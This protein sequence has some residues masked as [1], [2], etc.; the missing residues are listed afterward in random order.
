MIPEPGTRVSG[1]DEQDIFR[2]FCP[3]P[4]GDVR[5]IC[6]E[7][8]MRL[9]PG[10]VE[11]DIDLFGAAVNRIQEIGFKCIERERQSP[12]IRSLESCLRDEG[13]ACAGMSSFGPAVY[14]ITDSGLAG[15][16]AAAR[17]LLGE[18]AAVIRTR[19]DNKGAGTFDEP[20]G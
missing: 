14:A 15:L 18:R 2:E 20:V 10:V 9:L 11:H 13:A 1:R 12:G 3:V 17:N 6:H 8:V 19:A 4:I 5:E 16:E 7:V